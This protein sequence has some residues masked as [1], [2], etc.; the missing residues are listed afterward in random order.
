MRRTSSLL[1]RP[2]GCTPPF[3]HPGDLTSVVTFSMSDFF[4]GV[5]G[6]RLLRTMLAAGFLLVPAWADP[7]DDHR[8]KMAAKKVRA[9]GTARDVLRACE[10][11]P[12]AMAVVPEGAAVLDIDCKG[13]VNGWVW[14]AEH[15][16]G[17]IPT[18]AAVRTPSGGAH[19]YLKAPNLRTQVGVARG[20]DVF[21]P[22][23]IITVP[24]SRSFRGAYA[25]APDFALAKAPDSLLEVLPRR[26]APHGRRV[27]VRRYSGGA[28]AAMRAFS[29]YL[30][31]GGPGGSNLSG[32]LRRQAFLSGLRCDEIELDDL[33]T[34]VEIA[35]EY[36]MPEAEAWDVA[37]R[38]YNAGSVAPRRYRQ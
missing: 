12:G 24:G 15:L 10:G 21:G 30:R 32:R 23:S 14:L 34:L 13:P 11:R 28:P 17:W 4:H 3:A 38:G 16:P 36:G 1:T 7:D 19:I 5:N 33:A 27:R 18:R 22:G 2:V 8:L 31:A 35:V 20:V 37:V 26:E 29:V 25:P 6:K 9:Q